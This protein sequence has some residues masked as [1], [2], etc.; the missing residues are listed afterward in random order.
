M[1]FVSVADEIAKKSFT[2]VE[3]KFI[4]KYLKV[5]D[6]QSVKVYLFALHLSQ[7][8][9]V[10]YTLADLAQSL[11]MSEEEAIDCFKSLHEY[12]LVSILSENPFEIKILGANTYGKPKKYKPEKYA[13]FT[14]NA[15]SALDGRMISESEYRRYFEFLEEDGFDENAL[16]MIINYCVS[17]KGNKIGINYISTVVNS[18]RADGLL[19]AKKVDERLSAFTSSTPALLRLFAAVSIQKKPDIEDDKLYKKWTVELGFDDGAIICAAKHFKARSTEKIDAALE[20]LYRNKKFD[21]KEIDDYCK[22]KNSLYALSRTLRRNLGV[23]AQDDGPYVEN[24]VGVWSNFGYTA[25]CLEGISAYCF[26]H[27]KN[28]FAEMDEFV[29]SLYNEGIVT[30]ESVAEYIDERNAED[31]L[32]RKILENCGLSRKIVPWDRE[33]LSRWLNW[34]FTDDMLLE[35]AKRSATKSNPMAYMNSILSGWKAEGIFKVNDIPAEKAQK[36]ARGS[37]NSNLG[38]IFKAAYDRASE[39]EAAA[40]DETDGDDE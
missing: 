2:V 17:L 33:S 15:Q 35:A 30:E 21:Q 24:Y 16:L 36:R 29:R 13:D 6:A 34:G 27:G 12:E 10:E 18:F 37:K 8:S 38:D 40:A 1:P 39:N 25:D 5:L 14:K 23:Y 31:A 28:G 3:N 11:D 19:T 32:L 22:N 4:T 20:E 9:Q 26:T 7:N